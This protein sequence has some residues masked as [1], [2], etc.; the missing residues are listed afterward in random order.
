LLKD[1]ADLAS[2]SRFMQTLSSKF[3]SDAR[4]LVDG[5][6]AAMAR[7]DYEQFRELTHALKG[8]AMMAGAIRLR[9]SAARAERIT[10][11]DFKTAG[12]DLIQNLKG[13]LEA[14]NQEL[15]RMVA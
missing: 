9:D 4:Q 11:A 2:D 5:I 12:T 10:D 15:S 13:T 14:T 1:M 3:V 6:E 7:K 8:A